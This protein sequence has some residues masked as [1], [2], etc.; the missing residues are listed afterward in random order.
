MRGRAPTLPT[1]RGSG[2]IRPP[3]NIMHSGYLI[4]EG[5]PAHPMRTRILASE[6][7]PSTDAGRTALADGADIRYCAYFGDLD[8][9]MMH[10]HSA[11]RRHLLDVDAHLYR[12]D[13]ITAA[14]AADALDLRHHRV[15]M[16]T[17]T[18]SDPAFRELT[19][20]HR[21]HHRGLDRIWNGIGL[22]AIL[23]LV[24]K[25]LLGI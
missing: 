8:A 6:T 17:A 9:A 14:A 19:G 20:R 12:V 3:I 11:L 23:L 13:P 10:T 21:Q 24:I 16:D 2:I 15:F 22:A 5:H 1:A 18:A 4:I 25:L 7:P